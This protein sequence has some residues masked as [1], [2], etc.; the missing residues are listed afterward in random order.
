MGP[1]V[2]P[3]VLVAVGAEEFGAIGVVRAEVADAADEGAD[4]VDLGGSIGV[5]AH[6]FAAHSVLLRREREG[7][8]SSSIQIGVGGVEAIDLAV[9][10][11]EANVAEAERGRLLR[12]G[13][14][15]LAGAEEIEEREPHHVCE[16]IVFGSAPG[17]GD[18]CGPA[19]DGDGDRFYAMRRGVRAG[20]AGQEL[21]QPE[22][23]VTRGV[24]PDVG[25]AHQR[26]GLR[27]EA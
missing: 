3:A 18:G 11:A 19:K 6:N 8:E 21:L 23:D 16:A 9:H 20:P 15:V 10:V 24:E 22:V 5:M 4:G 27:H 26:V 25:E 7:S 2:G 17:P 1:D 12:C 14:R 13:A